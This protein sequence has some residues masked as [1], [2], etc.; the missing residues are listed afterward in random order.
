M[1]HLA[2]ALRSRTAEF[3]PLM[4][5]AWNAEL[6]HGRLAEQIDWIKG[7]GFGGFMI[8]PTRGLPYEV[9]AEPWLEAVEFALKRAQEHGLEVWIWD[10]WSFPSGFGGG[11][12]TADP[13][14][15]P[16]DSI[17]RSI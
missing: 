6:D 16:G 10:D 3:R 4:A 14:L 11:L 17:S 2:G 9:M 13:V 5:F 12:V 1:M 7:E 8:I 15:G